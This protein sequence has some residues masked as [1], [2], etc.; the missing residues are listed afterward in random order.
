MSDEDRPRRPR[1]QKP[2][3]R[4]SLRLEPSVD[5]QLDDLARL[6][7]LDR[8]TAVSVAITQDWIACFGGGQGGRRG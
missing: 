7:G 6:R 8:N 1:R 3:V 4:L 2:R 5:Q